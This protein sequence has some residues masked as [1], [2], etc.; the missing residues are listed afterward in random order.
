MARRIDNGLVYE[1]DGEIHFRENVLDILSNAAGLGLTLPLICGVLG[2]STTT[3]HTYLKHPVTGPKIAE[4][5]ASGKG[6]SA[7]AV[8]NALF[9]RASQGDVA[10]IRWY[11]MTRLNMSEKSDVAVSDNRMVVGEATRVED[12]DSWSKEA[13]EGSYQ[14]IEKQ[15]S[16]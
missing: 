13:V 4:A 8:A 7:Y 3:L 5:L 12:E 10:A 11:E 14:R 16:E 6:K 2:I 9:K 15:P 1:E